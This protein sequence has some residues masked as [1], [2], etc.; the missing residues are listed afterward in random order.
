[1]LQVLHPSTRDTNQ[2]RRR[3]FDCAEC[4]TEASDHPLQKSS[5]MTMVC[6]KCKKAFRKDVA[7]M[8]SPDEADEYCPHCDNHFL[9]EA[10][11][12]GGVVGLSGATVDLRKEERFYI[13]VIPADDRI[14][15]DDRVSGGGVQSKLEAIA[16]SS[17]RLG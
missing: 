6:K 5:V 17:G 16:D 3:W 7:D 11:T 8:E 14:V 9:R 1:M 2:F 13:F 12:K 15:R 4:H 10:V